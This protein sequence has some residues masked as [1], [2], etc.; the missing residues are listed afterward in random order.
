MTGQTPTWRVVVATAVFA[1]ASMSLVG[2]AP[3]IDGMVNGSLEEAV[4]RAQDVLW[5]HRERIVADPEPT[6]AGLG[7][8]SDYRAGV[9]DPDGSAS[10]TLFDLQETGEGT[11][12]TLLAGGGAQTGGGWTYDQRT[13]AVCFTL[14]FAADRNSI[15]T[16]PATCPD[17][18]RP[19][20]Y[21]SIV[22]LDELNPRLLVTN[23]DYPPPICQ[24]YSG[25][26]CD[27]PGG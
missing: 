17:I 15:S 7:F 1:F 3:S 14:T 5:E 18:P 26:P 16:S 25:S 13:A 8:V 6:I 23:E 21:D 20:R 12:L 10:Y 11:A 9:F 22:P 4:E 19:E 24:C 27:C 2:C